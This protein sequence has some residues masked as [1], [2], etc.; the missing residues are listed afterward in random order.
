MGVP[1]SQKLAKVLS[2]KAF[3]DMYQFKNGIKG[4]GPLGFQASV[5]DLKLDQSYVPVCRVS[6]VEWKDQKSPTILENM[7]DINNKKSDGD[8]SITLARPLSEDHIINCPIVEPDR[9]NK[10]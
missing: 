6:I 3:S 5:L 7:D 4:S 8:I 10:G 1:V 9:S 2:S